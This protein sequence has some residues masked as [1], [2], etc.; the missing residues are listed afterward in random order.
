[1]VCHDRR[2]EGEH[3]P[4]AAGLG[5]DYGMYCSTIPCSERES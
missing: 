1:M 4:T 5:V 3:A 2:L